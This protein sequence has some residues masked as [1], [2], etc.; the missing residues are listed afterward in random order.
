MLDEYRVKIGRRRATI[1]WYERPNSLKASCLEATVR[2]LLQHYPPQNDLEI[3]PLPRRNVGRRRLLGVC[4]DRRLIKL[5]YA[6]NI[7]TVLDILCHEW[8]HAIG[9]RE[10]LPCYLLS[11]LVAPVACASQKRLSVLENPVLS[12]ALLR[13]RANLPW[14]AAVASS[15]A[16]A[17]VRELLT[18]LERVLMA[19]GLPTDGSCVP[20]EL[21]TRLRPRSGAPLAAQEDRQ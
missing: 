1:C 15:E 14:P 3:V 20:F 16:E 11:D 4:A 10:E 18:P 5:A 2:L 17:L 7:V 21:V 6:H 8:G 12:A 13:D 19:S 9:Y